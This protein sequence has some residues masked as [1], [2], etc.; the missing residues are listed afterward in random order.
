[1]HELIGI[2]VCTLSLGTLFLIIDMRSL[3]MWDF[4]KETNMQVTKGLGNEE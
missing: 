4:A 1:M 3:T 2:K